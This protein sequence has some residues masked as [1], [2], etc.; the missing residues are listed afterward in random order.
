M[1]K[2]WGLILV[3]VSMVTLI[4]CSNNNK[5]VSGEWSPKESIEVVA[6]AGAGSGWDTTARM[7]AKIFEEEGM[8]EQD[9]GVVNKPGGGGAV[10]WAYV[11]EKAGNPHHM[12]IASP[13]IID[14]PLK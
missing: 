2:K 10:G 3:F 13:P 1:G 12:F 8:I 5:A 7:T 9:I 4:A 14:V 11:A 6:P